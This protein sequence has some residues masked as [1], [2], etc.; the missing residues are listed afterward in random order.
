VGGMGGGG[1]GRIGS[2]TERWVLE[3]KN[4]IRGSG[5]ERERSRRG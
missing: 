3:Q 1:S 2:S 5:S 4:K